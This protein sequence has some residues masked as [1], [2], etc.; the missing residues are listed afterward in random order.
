[1]YLHTIHFRKVLK[2]H[3]RQKIVVDYTFNQK[4]F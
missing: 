2:K 1:M 3:I 4:K